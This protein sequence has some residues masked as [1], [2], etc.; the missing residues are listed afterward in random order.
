MGK[1]RQFPA[2]Y[3]I[4][5]VS[6]ETVGSAISQGRMSISIIVLKSMSIVYIYLY[7]TIQILCGHMYIVHNY[8]QTHI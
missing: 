8:I 3:F 5:V 6:Y 4:L 2:L 7:S 1:S